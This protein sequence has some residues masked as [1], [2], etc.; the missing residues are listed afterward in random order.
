MSTKDQKL[1]RLDRMAKNS[2][3]QGTSHY[4]KSN[5]TDDATEMLAHTKAMD[6]CYR[7]SISAQLTELKVKNVSRRV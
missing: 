3:M 6:C 5:E 7:T 1:Q 4:E 2:E